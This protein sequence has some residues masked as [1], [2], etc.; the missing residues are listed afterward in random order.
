MLGKSSKGKV[1]F[2]V[3][4]IH[5]MLSCGHAHDQVRPPAT[6]VVKPEIQARRL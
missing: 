5:C 6:V 3:K 2:E 4:F 1:A